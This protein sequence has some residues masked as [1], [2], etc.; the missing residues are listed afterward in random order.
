MLV[1]TFILERT[2]VV[3]LAS[4]YPKTDL[5]S[6]GVGSCQAVGYF[7]NGRGKLLKTPNFSARTAPSSAFGTFSPRKKPRGEK[8]SRQREWQGSRGNN[9][10][11]RVLHSPP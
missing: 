5:Q 2:V 7:M 1:W 10:T 11:Q 8:D 3:Y 4:T 6:R 9:S